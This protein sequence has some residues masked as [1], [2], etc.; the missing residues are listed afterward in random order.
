MDLSIITPAAPHRYS[1]I[2]SM[3]D[4]LIL[5]KVNNPKIDFEFILVDTSVNEEYLPLYK[6]YHTHLKFKY[7]FLP[8]SH[9]YPN[10]SYIRN[11]GFR[12]AQGKVFTMLDADHW[13]HEDFIY[14]A[15]EIKDKD[16]L[17]TGF[18]I[19]TSKCVNHNIHEDVI[20]Y[21]LQNA[22]WVKFNKIT[23]LL[24]I[25][26]RKCARVWLAAYPA[27][28]IFEMNG[29]DEK[30]CLGYSTEDDDLYY[31]LAAQIPIYKDSWKTFAGLHIW[32]P[33]NARKDN[34]VNKQYYH[35][36][37][38]KNFVRN[39][40]H[41]WGK[42]VQGGHTIIENNKLLFNDHEEWIKNNIAIPTYISPWNDFN[43]LVEN[44]K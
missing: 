44:L 31:R 25:E 19:D 21:M 35:S 3:C 38:P 29:Y 8:I 13:V 39:K 1:R 17:N 37:D 33:Q 2:R 4:R 12:I 11:V 5:N 42:L 22:S 36:T 32:H 16:V 30:Y 23:S 10:P 43:N 27:N 26:H 9:Q 20:K 28:K 24:G 18:M 15:T 6:F 14:G 34:S 7:I 40:N 41:E